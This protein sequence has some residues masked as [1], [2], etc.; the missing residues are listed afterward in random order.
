M[1]RVYRQRFVFSFPF[2]REFAQR[3]VFWKGTAVQ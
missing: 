1:A 3:F 2:A